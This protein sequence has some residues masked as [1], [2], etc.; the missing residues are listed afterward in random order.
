MNYYEQLYYVYSAYAANQYLL[1][2]Y[3]K[4]R[5]YL[6]KAQEARGKING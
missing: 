4:M 2:N 6:R 1:G 5:E 3:E